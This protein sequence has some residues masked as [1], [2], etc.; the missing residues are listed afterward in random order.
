MKPLVRLILIFN[1]LIAFC[2]SSAYADC[3]DKT[4]RCINNKGY[5][6]ETGQVKMGQCLA[7][8]LMQCD[9]CKHTKYEKYARECNENNVS[10]CKGNCYACYPAD[11]SSFS[12]QLTCY[13]SDGRGH[14]IR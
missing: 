7:L 10:E 13:D 9:D 11:G 4:L 14:A 5:G 1:V 6:K 8:P 12:G 3:G 2:G